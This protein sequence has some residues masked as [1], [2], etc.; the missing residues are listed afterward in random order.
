MKLKKKKVYRFS[1][2]DTPLTK[3][4]LS[5]YSSLSKF[6]VW[7]NGEVTYIPPEMPV[8]DQL[9]YCVGGKFMYKDQLEELI[10]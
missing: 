4:Q 6:F 8:A 1:D 3:E 7:D 5:T 10:S 9:R 2:S